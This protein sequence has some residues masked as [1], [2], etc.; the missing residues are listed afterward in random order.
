MTWVI[1]GLGNPGDEYVRTRHNA[2]RMGVE[3]YAKEKGFTDWK[4]DRNAKSLV[5]R[6]AI[7]RA[8]AVCVLP[9]TFMNRSGSAV[10]HYIQGLPAAE[11]LIVVY[12]D[13]DLPVGTI[14]ISFDRGTGGHNGVDSIMR[15]IKTRRFTRIR[16]GI[17][18]VDAE[19]VVHKPRGAKNVNE[20]VLGDFPYADL[21]ALQSSLKRAG[22]AIECVVSEG[23]VIAM[24][25]FN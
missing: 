21:P 8:M 17:S 24:N 10:L 16:I 15:T 11:R 22:E 6:G 14:K 7:G 19:G 18:P 5:T 20:Y 12:D 9:L 2:G 4:E 25:K 23:W 13:I 1:V 3:A